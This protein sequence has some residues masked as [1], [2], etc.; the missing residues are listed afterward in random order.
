MLNNGGFAVTY[1]GDAFNEGMNIV[2]TR[3]RANGQRIGFDVKINQNL[4][5]V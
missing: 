3:F 5:G 1:S 2:F 4:L